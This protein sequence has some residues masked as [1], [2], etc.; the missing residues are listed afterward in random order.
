M[1]TRVTPERNQVTRRAAPVSRTV[2]DLFRDRLHWFLGPRE[3]V[4]APYIVRPETIRNFDVLAFSRMKFG[5]WKDLQRFGADIASSLDPKTL[6]NDTVFTSVAYDD[7]RPSGVQLAEHALSVLNK[8]RLIPLRFVRL[9]KQNWPTVAD[10]G[11]LSLEDR[12]RSLKRVRYSVDPK[13]VRG[14]HLVVIDDARV[15]GGHED[16]IRKALKGLPRSITFAYAVSLEGW[17]DPNLEQEITLSAIE[18]LESL[19]EIMLGEGF[20]VTSKLCKFILA[21][22]DSEGVKSLLATL[23]NH[24][25]Y[26]LRSGIINSGYAQ[27]RQPASNLKLIQE[28]CEAR[29][30]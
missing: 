7:V 21:H 22:S 17:D 23:P 24:I 8:D 26:A 19:R 29:G 28:I 3:A 15:T 27:L 25:L 2:K 30:L 16:V 5:S 20:S 10:Y 11:A 14:K 1:E 4:R 18:S 9:A 12:K 13:L 6:S